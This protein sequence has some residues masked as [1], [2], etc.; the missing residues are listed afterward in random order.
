MNKRYL[1]IAA[2]LTTLGALA[3]FAVKAAADGIP[4]PN[5][6]YYSGTLTEGGKV[7]NDTRA[8]TVYLW[9]DKTTTGTPLCQ[10]VASTTNVVDGRFR[11]ALDSSCKSAINQN[12]NVYVEVVD[13]A[14]SLGRAP[15]GA[16]PYAV[17]ADRASGAAG[18]LATQIVPSGAVMAFDLAA[19][20]QGWQAL[21][22]AVGSVIIGVGP[23][24][25][26]GVAVGSDHVTLSTAQMPVHTHTVVDPGHMHPNPSGTDNYLTNVYPSTCADSYQ[27]GAAITQGGTGPICP[28]TTTGNATTGI[29]I[30]SAGSGQS[31]DNRQASFPL[32]Y[33]KKS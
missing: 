2:G 5:P 22:G 9:P 21:P 1:F 23:G 17:E 6:L 19:C 29:T 4:S 25:T 10:T 15:L 28:A 30:E 32:L 24:L 31:F 33:C 12:A 27:A 7:V 11:I 20:P 13:G 14:T 18:T 26:L 3:G 8:I 16:V